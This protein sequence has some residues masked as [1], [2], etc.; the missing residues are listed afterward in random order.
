MTT[1]LGTLV[2]KLE[3]DIT[4]L[5]RRLDEAERSA[6]QSGR[7]MGVS[8]KDGILLGI[9]SQIGSQISQL[10]ATPINIATRSI[11]G[12]IDQAFQKGQNFE[13]F[14]ASLKTILGDAAKAKK[15]IGDLAE[16]ARTT[17]FELPELQAATRSLLSYGFESEKLIDTLTRIGDVSSALSLNINELAVIY[18][19]G[20]VAGRLYQGDINELTGRGIP[21]IQEFAKQFGVTDAE[22]RKLT[23]TGRLNFPQ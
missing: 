21:I 9:G 16:F 8:I 14:E 11:R 4:E 12:F 15:L 19:K 18:G 2:L 17:P 22:V 1:N 6:R 10:I 5:Q 3:A 20:R 23:E 7:Q 13:Q